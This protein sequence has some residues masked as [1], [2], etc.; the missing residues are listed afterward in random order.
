VID[1]GVDIWV[2]HLDEVAGD[3]ERLRGLLDSAEMERAARF[4]SEPARRRFI[5]RHGIRRLILAGYLEQPAKDI[6][7][8]DGNGRKPR[9]R[10]RQPGGFAFNQSASDELAVIAVARGVEIGI[11]V[12]RIRPVPDAAGIVARF[13]S[14]FE[15]ASYRLVPEHDRDAAFLRWWTAKEAFLKM[16]GTGLDYPLN[17]F[18]V[19]FPLHAPTLPSPASGGGDYEVPAPASGGGDYE[20]RFSLIELTPAAGYVGTLIVAGQPPQIRQ[21]RWTAGGPMHARGAA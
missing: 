14:A 7:V 8:L 4:R 2:A 16:I 19:S 1:A 10:D 17:A 5:A 15:V 11:D 12:E 6:V 13:G 18:S 9:V 3:V 21:Y 20:R